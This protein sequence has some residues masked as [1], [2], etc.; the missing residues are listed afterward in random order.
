MSSI[1]SRDWRSHLEQMKQLQENIGTNSSGAKSQLEKL[2]SDIENTLDK[3][4][5]R[6][7]YLNAHLDPVLDE[8]RACQV[9]VYN[10][11]FSFEFRVY[12]YACYIYLNFKNT[13]K[14]KK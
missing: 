7:T 5:T 3:I 1:E 9:K 14:V 6:E 8:F 4:K 13:I 2:H 12:W 10:T 11:V